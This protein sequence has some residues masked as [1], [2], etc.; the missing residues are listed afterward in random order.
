LAASIPSQEDLPTIDIDALEALRDEVNAAPKVQPSTPLGPALPPA[1]NEL[2][3]SPMGNEVIETCVTPRKVLAVQTTLQ[4]EH[5]RYRCAVKLLPFFFTKEEL[6]TSNTEGS[7]GKQRLDR[8][9]LNSL[10]VLVFNKFPVESHEE[11]EKLW[12]FIK[13]KI[14][15]R[16]RASKF[17]GV[18]KR[19]T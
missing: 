19:D 4:G 8:N 18:V 2:D 13:T 14:N 12:K 3:Q 11:K 10:K 6:G 5:S 15:A 17:N 16:C 7:H 9:K 1:D